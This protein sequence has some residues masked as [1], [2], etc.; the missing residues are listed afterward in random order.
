MTIA[1]GTI[2]TRAGPTAKPRPSARSPA[3]TP[4]AA[5][6]PKADPPESTKASTSDTVIAGS[7]SAVSR[8]PGAPPSTL[9][10]AVAGRSKTMAVTPEPSARSVAWPTRTPAMSVRRLCMDFGLPGQFPPPGL[11]QNRKNLSYK[12][13]AVA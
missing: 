13:N 8:P 1:C 10:E 5:S 2:G 12:D 4:P 3:C 7:R 6:S 11:Y 9:P